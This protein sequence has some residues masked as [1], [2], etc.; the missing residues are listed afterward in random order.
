MAL[1]IAG[2]LLFLGMHFTGILADDWRQTMIRK[3]GPGSWKLLYSA[4]SVAGLILII[5]GYGAAR[6]D[7]VFLWAAPV[8]TRH[9]AMP[10]TLV[11][12][13]LLAAAYVP[14]NRIKARLGHPMLA[15]VKIWAFAHLLANGT[16][17]DVLLF[18]SFLV[19][20]IA[21]FAVLRR[22]DRAN[23]VIRT[24]AIKGDILTLVAGI[25]AWAVF[26]MA[27]HAVLI[28]VSPMP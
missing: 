23:G 6:T 16:L 26:A 4:V 15:A 7:P 2:L 5:I 25:V 28:G 22:R 12:F 11:A 18:G 10:L 21:G 24:G 27:L 8:W 19:W 20:A 13:I 3:M 1:L 14:Q 17:A 9:L